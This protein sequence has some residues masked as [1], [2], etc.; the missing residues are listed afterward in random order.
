MAHRRLRKVRLALHLE[1][2]EILCALRMCLRRKRFVIDQCP[3]RGRHAVLPGNGLFGV[4]PCQLVMGDEY[5]IARLWAWRV[6]RNNDLTLFAMEH[7]SRRQL[8]S[9]QFPSRSEM[10]LKISTQSKPLSSGKFT[11]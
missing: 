5:T 1:L 2:A 11:F 3:R 9:H 7:K 6:R 10:S 8:V 4:E